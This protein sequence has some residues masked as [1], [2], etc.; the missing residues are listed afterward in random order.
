M[1]PIVGINVDIT[2]G[3]PRE[4]RVQSFYFEAVER[5]GGIP[6]LVPPM[7]DEDLDSVLKR[8]NGI[9]LIGG[10]DYCPSTYGEEL[11]DEEKRELKV[12]IAHEMRH[13]FDFRLVKRTLEE[14]RLPI[15]G[16]CA[17][18]QLL[19]ISLGGSLIPDIVSHLP[20]S[21]V[22]HASPNGWNEGFNKHA[23]KLKPNTMVA[24]IYK[25][26]EVVVPTSHHQAVSRL[27]QG[28]EATAYA[29][30]GII[31]A[32]ELSG[33]PFTIGVQWH[34]ERDFAGNRLLFEEFVKECA[35]L[36]MARS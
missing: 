11:S 3:P 29:E 15:L 6:L 26:E 24:R 5:A 10:L 23:V 33:R 34:P 9:L 31:E 14:T 17:G 20:D 36:V 19:N 27:G 32:V 8:L 4:A 2:A 13:D 28:L 7:P 16:I 1:K 22:R 18:C 35:Q 21:E 25:Q 12:E 30:D